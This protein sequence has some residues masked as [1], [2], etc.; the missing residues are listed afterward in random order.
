MAELINTSLLLANP[1][2][3]L[4]FIYLIIVF[5]A[6]VQMLFNKDEKKRAR[7]GVF[8]GISLLIIMVLGIYFL[9]IERF[10]K[11]AHN[12]P[13]SFGYFIMFVCGMVYLVIWSL[14]ILFLKET[15]SH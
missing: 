6:L 2:I 8:A 7:R 1:A 12:D 15:M 3:I 10:I 13:I 11:S 9:G 14:K 4:V 5:T